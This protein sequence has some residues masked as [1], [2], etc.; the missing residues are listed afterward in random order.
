[1][2]K[3]LLL[4]TLLVATA[5]KLFAQE[6]DVIK[7]TWLNEEKDAKI[8]IYKSGDKYFGK[9]SWVKDAYE[10]DGKTLRKDIKNPDVQL[11]NRTIVN[12]VILTGLQYDD[13]E[14]TGGELYDP[15][16]GKTYKSKVKLKNAS[17]EIRGY[18]GAPMFGKTTV[19]SRA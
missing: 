14:W 19:W 2:K 18:V 1:M 9:I 8:E 4:V 10:A 7:G 11:R 3:G 13:G 6:A 12:C 16:T 15:K 17:L 5:I